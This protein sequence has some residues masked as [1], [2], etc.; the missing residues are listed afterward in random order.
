MINTAGTHAHTGNTRY[1]QYPL[2]MSSSL[3]EVMEALQATVRHVSYYPGVPGLYTTI[4]TTEFGDAML[5]W[6]DDRDTASITDSCSALLWVVEHTRK[7]AAPRWL[8][9]VIA[10]TRNT[11][12]QLAVSAYSD[13]PTAM[14]FRKVLRSLVGR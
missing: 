7:D 11:Y 12:V 6:L 2:Y 5:R 8:E 3:A 13:N 14:S 9:M 10:T 4:A 1:S